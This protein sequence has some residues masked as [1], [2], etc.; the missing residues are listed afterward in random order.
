MSDNAKS[1]KTGHYSPAL[2]LRKHPPGT[3]FCS[4]CGKPQYDVKKL[5]AG[6]GVFI[7]NECVALCEK[8][9]ADTPDPN[10][11]EIKNLDT[12]E[13]P[14]VLG[15][16]KGYNMAYIQVRDRMQE[17]VDILRK[18]EVSWADIAAALG[19]SRQAAWERF[20]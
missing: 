4:F 2:D 10:P 3:M 17:A 7:C 18:R 1:P 8:I 6:P 5:I 12:L 14:T 16:I 9:M 20:S 19:V 11:A 15:M 13:T